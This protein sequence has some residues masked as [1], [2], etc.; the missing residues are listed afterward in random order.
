MRTLL[1]SDNLTPDEAARERNKSDPIDTGSSPF[2]NDVSFFFFF[3]FYYSKYILKIL[4]LSCMTA[5]LTGFLI[6]KLWLLVSSM[7]TVAEVV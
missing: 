1:S 5:V 7:V 4:Y 2:A 3:V 6:S